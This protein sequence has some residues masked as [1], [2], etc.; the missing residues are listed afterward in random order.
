[1][2]K[3]FNQTCDTK[4]YLAT[5]TAK[6]EKKYTLNRLIIKGNG[7]SKLTSML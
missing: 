7:E 1:M 6:H 4:Y 5:E 3:N 2:G